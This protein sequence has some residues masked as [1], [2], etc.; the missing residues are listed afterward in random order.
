MAPTGLPSLLFTPLHYF[1]LCR[2]TPPP[3]TPPAAPCCSACA[4]AANLTEGWLRSWNVSDNYRLILKPKNEPEN[5]FN[6]ASYHEATSE[7]PTS[8]Y[9]NTCNF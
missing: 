3:P 6:I 9:R 1:R 7:P 8:C 5:H 4:V 2:P